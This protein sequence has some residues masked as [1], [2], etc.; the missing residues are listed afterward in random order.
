MNSSAS[1]P[2][3]TG[4]LKKGAR[5]RIF[6]H[7]GTIIDF[8]PKGAG[9]NLFA[10]VIRTDEEIIFENVRGNIVIMQL[11]YAGAEWGGGREVD[12]TVGAEL[13]PNG[14]QYPDV[15]SW[16]KNATC[17]QLDYGLDY[18]VL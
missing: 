2:P 7:N 10:A 12:R 1:P 17:V 14:P 6:R 9:D 15:P 5:V 16:F 4:K 3:P 8:I 18:E 13:C 11:R